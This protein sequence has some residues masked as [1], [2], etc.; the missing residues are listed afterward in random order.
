MQYT[1]AS[2]KSERSVFG[3]LKGARTDDTLNRLGRALDAY[4]QSKGVDSERAALIE[5][6]KL[7]RL[8]KR[9]HPEPGTAK[10]GIVD[11]I[12]NA[13]RA[14]VSNLWVQDE[15]LKDMTQAASADDN[16][17]LPSSIS[18]LKRKNA[19]GKARQFATDQGKDL[20]TNRLLAE[21]GIS[22]AEHT[23]LLAFIGQDYEYMN[24]A[25]AADEAWMARKRPEVKRKDPNQ[26][27]PVAERE[28]NRYRE[29]GGMHSA[30]ALR[31]LEKLPA[32]KG[33]VYRGT[34]DPP[35]RIP[36]VGDLVPVTAI[37]SWSQN[38]HTAAAFASTGKAPG[39]KSVI[40]TMNTKR[41]KNINLLKGADDAGVEP[42]WVLVP[43]GSYRVTDVKP[44]QKMFGLPRVTVIA[45][46]ELS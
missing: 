36:A 3:Q 15:Y 7:C 8:Y 1:S 28:Y 45:C 9:R 21:L 19:A 33:L 10:Y 18:K 31:A 46:E 26:Y 2:V 14:E 38:P 16:T 32:S 40:Y 25:V 29:Q 27:D 37:Q 17:P 42:E 43:G 11:D 22:L 39:E 34:H 44:E 41:A 20:A 4:H 24:P 35:E 13:V 23:G 12:E 5:V 6:N 30:F